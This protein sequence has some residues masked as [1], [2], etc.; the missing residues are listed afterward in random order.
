MMILNPMILYRMHAE[1]SLA[2]PNNFTAADAP[3][4]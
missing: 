4:P 3:Q 2:V 1:N